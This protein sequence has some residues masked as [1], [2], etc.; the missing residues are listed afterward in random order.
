MDQAWTR[1][2]AHCLHFLQDISR[3]E[4]CFNP[5]ESSEVSA[6]PVAGRS[7]CET[8]SS[9]R[10]G[11]LDHHR[12]WRLRLCGG[13]RLSGCWGGCFSAGARPIRPGRRASRGELNE[14]GIQFMQI[15]SPMDISMCEMRGEWARELCPM[16]TT[17]VVSRSLTFPNRWKLIQ[18]GQPSNIVDR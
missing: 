6:S 13:C 15:Y 3:Q 7:V 10:G 5:Q 11:R 9:P 18:Q 2:T 12:R 1:K 14:L 17:S 16:G 4:F 8:C